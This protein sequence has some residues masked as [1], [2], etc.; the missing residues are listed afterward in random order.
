MSSVFPTRK[1]A[2]HLP[3]SRKA[4]DMSHR[5]EPHDFSRN[6]RASLPRQLTAAALLGG[7]A[8]LAMFLGVGL[9][10]AQA[11]D[12][13]G[14]VGS[15]Y[16]CSGNQSAG[17][18][19]DSTGT[20]LYVN[21][22]TGDINTDGLTGI[23][24]N[25]D[26]PIKAYIDT[27][28]YAIRANGPQANGIYLWGNG[29]DQ[30]IYLDETG[31]IYSEQGNGV[32]LDGFSN[33]ETHT[34]G[35][36]EAAADAIR[37]HSAY[38]GS[39]I[40]EHHG[41]LTST[42]GYGVIADGQGSVGVD[43]TGDINSHYDGIRATSAGEGSDGTVT[44][45]YDGTI[46]STDGYGIYANS[47]FHSTKVTSTGDVNSKLD[48]IVVFSGGDNYDATATLEQYGN[49]TSTDGEGIHVES[50]FHSAK[51]TIVGDVEGKKNGVVVIAN[52]DNGDSTAYVHM[53]GNVTSASG[54]GIYATSAFH[55]ASVKVEGD[56]RSGKDGVR[57]VATGSSYDATATI[58]SD[59]DVTSTNGY[60]LYALSEYQAAWVKST[61]TIESKLDAI[62][63]SS[64]GYYGNVTVTSTGNL[65]SHSGSGI[66][67]D[68]AYQTANVTSRGD[69]YAAV[70]GIYA[71]TTG[72]T[73][74]SID[75][76]GNITGTTGYGLFAKSANGHAAVESHGNVTSGLDG[77]HAESTGTSAAS[78][79]SVLSNGDVTSTAGTGIYVRS[80]NREA[81]LLSYGD[82]SGY[83]GGI[84]V[85][86]EGTN[87]DARAYV[88]QYGDVT[89]AHGTGIYLRSVSHGATLKSEGSV[90]ANEDGI[91]VVTEGTGSDAIASVQ[92]TG[93]VTATNGYGVYATATN[94]GV[95]VDVTG[96][97]QSK[98]DGVYALSTGSG[99]DAT[100]NVD[101]NGDITSSQGYGIYAEATN[102]GVITTG[103]GDIYGR[104][105]GIYAVTTGSDESATIRIT[106]TGSVSSED[107]AAIYGYASNK[108]VT[109]AQNG[110]VTGGQ[111]GIHA[112]AESAA[113]AVSFGEDG[114][115]SGAV[116]AA[117]FL[118]GNAKNGLANY[119]EIDGGD[120]YAVKTK[121]YGTT[122][123]DN[124]GTLTGDIYID[125]GYSTVFNM[126]AGTF[127]LGDVTFTDG[128]LVKNMGTLSAG[129]V[130]T[131][132]TANIIDG[133]F[134][135]TED[136][137]L[138][139]DIDGADA[140]LINVGYHAELSGTVALN[141][142]T[143]A[144]LTS[145]TILT[146]EGIDIETMDLERDGILS[147]YVMSDSD[148]R[149]VNGTDL[150]VDV[151]LDFAPTGLDEK[152][153]GIGQALEDAYHNE[154]DDLGLLL[155]QLANLQT[156]EEYEAALEELGPEIQVNDTAAFSALAGQFTNKLFSCR[157][158]DGAY[159]FT[160][161]G[162]CQWVSVSHSRTV[163][164]AT[165][166]SSGLTS[167][168]TNIA[169]GGQWAV[170]D[171]LRFGVA[172]G[173][174]SSSSVDGTGA[175]AVGESGELGTVLKYA[176]DGVIL[177]AALTAGWGSTD[178]ER[179]VN[180]GLIDQTITGTA[181]SG[182]VD[183]R[184]SAGYEFEIGD[185]YLKP[186]V[187]L[188]LKQTYFG[189]M[190][191]AGGSAAL[192]LADGS[193]FN[194]ILTPSLELGGEVALSE[195]TVARPFIR[196]GG[197]FSTGNELSVDANFVG[198]D[199]TFKVTSESDDL[200]AT[201][202]AGVDIVNADNATVRL[203]YDG[204]F[205]ETT[206]TDSVAFKL[207]GKL[208]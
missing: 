187:N 60:G 160:A 196:V 62:N 156:K 108:S 2:S 165:D 8:H 161:E 71:V 14:L 168:E 84:Y 4:P 154:N 131:V 47:S 39:V 162:E 25:S 202:S 186:L 201:L 190:T 118:E 83:S 157:V 51:A 81:K 61:G 20:D 95:I 18:W 94:R 55:S 170:G 101:V 88:E 208:F 48:G 58:E 32:W 137:V 205:G 23:G 17:I 177:G 188:D 66:I 33:V 130:G 100:V 3:S 64:N 105:G 133:G 126:A 36:I 97:I 24:F 189:G 57:V 167:D 78:T 16:T 74:A 138:V 37:A 147:T 112:V 181:E 127:N 163:T 199:T 90:I 164:D 142:I 107:G 103:T 52:G 28:G 166:S 30:S 106:H 117:V 176:K 11:N 46:N 73:T 12:A 125:D 92:H 67:A 10:P 129:G 155:G 102:M 41:T 132:A 203:V 99:S 139:V 185:A 136:G 184:L 13:C 197:A 191:E 145:Y 54:Y 180:F 175:T 149:V 29:D 65:T 50:S 150:V 146:S 121:G 140:D 69:I 194:A 93:N 111:Y 34:S 172:A 128:G 151:L 96:N 19:I 68:S 7:V 169:A 45:G 26:G 171:D 98:K 110:D 80:A 44:V 43:V 86:S 22:L 76:V 193:V 104:H 183:A 91:V 141:F 63:V 200:A 9:A 178:T 159:R 207:S 15:T 56:I 27:N 174:T 182:Y 135:Q 89:S 1:A 59:G 114:V 115:L 38:S 120:G 21:S 72:D 198:E 79:A 144:D 87:P 206:R 143:V 49:V 5:P 31:D 6:P 82:V 158:Q 204:T 42:G 77:I 134:V 122:A 179:F 173:Y 123:I 35:N 119:G 116:D 40:V 192:E 53:T 152:Y 148:L 113:V 153:S 109:I 75:S 70:N 195:S 124:Y 85:L